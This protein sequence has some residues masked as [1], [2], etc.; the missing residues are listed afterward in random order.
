MLDLDGNQAD[1][2]TEKSCMLQTASWLADFLG[3]DQ[4]GNILSVSHLVRRG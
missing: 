1:V 4:K 3:E 2:E